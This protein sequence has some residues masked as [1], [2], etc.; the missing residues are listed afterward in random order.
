MQDIEYNTVITKLENQADGLRKE[1]ERLVAQWSK[2]QFDIHPRL[3]HTYHNLFGQLEFSLKK[4][5]IYSESTKQKV[6]LLRERLK[7]GEKITEETLKA[8]DHYV[9]LRAG[10]KVSIDNNT[11]KTTGMNLFQTIDNESRKSLL[12]ISPIEE[13][14]EMTKIYRDLVKKL[15][16]DKSNHSEQF[17]RYWD[18][19]QV[20][21]KSS[22]LERLRLYHKILC[23]F[24]YKKLCQKQS[25]LNALRLEINELTKTIENE[26]EKIA[27]IK[28][29]EPFCLENKFKNEIWISSRKKQLE[30]KIFFT[31]V[32]IRKHERRLHSITSNE[33][34]QSA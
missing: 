25:K 27:K 1:L 32:S 33:L 26:K 18:P 19:V 24:D 23:P 12:P 3:V 22:N 31:E 17:K 2:L 28:E 13:K 10:E 11:A 7:K 21:Y 5:A 9:S 20:A 8:I 15:H 16:P 30:N 4:K 34:K 14:Y 29:R 6:E